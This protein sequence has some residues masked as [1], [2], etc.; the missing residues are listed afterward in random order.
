M[1]FGER[2]EVLG[3]LANESLSAQRKRRS[4]PELLSTR[5]EE[6]TCL[7]FLDGSRQEKRR[8]VSEYVVRF[9]AARVGLVCEQVLANPKIG[10]AKVE[11]LEPRTR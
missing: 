7:V 5:P 8:D 9:E 2:L 3:G 11:N 4:D 6:R 1:H 10:D